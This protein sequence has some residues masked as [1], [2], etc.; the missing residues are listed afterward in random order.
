[1][2]AGPPKRRRLRATFF[3]A[4]SI[5]AIAIACSM[6]APD[7]VAPRVAD[8][9]A[10]PLAPEDVMF[11]FQVDKP[12]SASPSNLPPRYPDRLRAA[13]IEGRVVGKFVVDTNGQADMRTFEVLKSD[14]PDF[15]AA[16]R[17]ALPN[18]RF[19]PARVGGRAVKQL[20]QMPF[21]FSLVKGEPAGQ[22]K[23]K[24][25]YEVSIP[26]TP[27]VLFE[28]AA[29]DSVPGFI[30][31]NAPPVYPTQL[32]AANF[33][34]MVQAKFVV[35]ADGTAD[36]STFLVSRSDHE[37]FTNAVRTAV[38]Q[39]RFRPATKNGKPVAAMIQMPFMFSLSR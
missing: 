31:A 19:Q 5:V 15:V 21:S 16:V 11:D 29:G 33:Q 2:T 12:A 17:E 32:R 4:A 36:M 22:R 23:P 27:Q 38:A 18:M 26:G 35:R 24:I 8:P 7:V 28:T 10:R 34:G 30:S 1:M 39:W 20:I 13:N 25:D 14:H 6:P 9:L 37:A 3:A